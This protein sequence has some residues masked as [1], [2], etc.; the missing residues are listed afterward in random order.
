[1]NEPI[2]H[3]DAP[4]ETAAERASTPAAPGRLEHASQLVD[5]DGARRRDPGLLAELAADPRARVMRVSRGAVAVR[6][7]EPPS[8]AD[9]S[10]AEAGD[11]PRTGARAEVPT[12]LWG[13]VEVPMRVALDPIGAAVRAELD[14]AVA[15][16]TAAVVYLGL[17]TLAG[18]EHEAG[19]P[20]LALIDEAPSSQ[21]AD[22]ELVPLRAL[23]GRLVPIDHE[24]AT[25]ATA[26]REW[27]R[28][29]AWSP[30]S[31]DPLE[32][33]E[34]GWLRQDRHG[35]P[36]FP[37]TDA[38]IIA[39]VVDPADGTPETERILLGSNAKW[40]RRRF[41]LLAGFVEPG[42][43]FEQAVEREI[44]EESGIRI[45][46]P[47]YVGSQ[48]WPFPASIMVGFLADLH[49]QQDPAA[50]VP[51]PGEIDELRW[52]TR[53]ELEA[54]AVELPPPPTI[55]RRIIDGWLRGDLR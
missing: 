8:E 20:V 6:A 51:E 34:A 21:P 13:V 50:L 22:A 15:A 12:D 23:L 32:I 48:P 47:R 19:A 43:S 54:G 44:A 10:A 45:A 38:A 55:A 53:A 46:N 14:A 11:D 7:A 39:A 25:T 1:M 35:S 4:R 37:R 18:P 17:A 29:H 33:G 3:P 26:M 24:L 40:S 41:S 30:A 16:E 36:S 27:H 9:A 49:P 28:A 42:E 52:L 31:G 5:R 2:R